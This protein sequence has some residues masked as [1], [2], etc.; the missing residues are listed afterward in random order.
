MI[1]KIP[2]LNFLHSFCHFHN[3]FLIA[4]PNLLSVRDSQTLT[5]AEIKLSSW[6][7][8]L[9][10]TTTTAKNLMTGAIGISSIPARLQS[11]L[12]KKLEN[13]IKEAKSFKRRLIKMINHSYPL[14]STTLTRLAISYSY[15]QSRDTLKSSQLTLSSIWPSP[16]RKKW[17]L[18]ITTIIISLSHYIH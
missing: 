10:L 17:S 13:S 4:S 8:F 11:E 3:S 2:R 18:I 16:S 1:K 14:V 9:R 5:H 6:Y 12:K 15:I 7:K